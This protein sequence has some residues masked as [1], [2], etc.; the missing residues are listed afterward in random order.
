MG[1]LGPQRQGESDMIDE[2]ELL[3][4][5]AGLEVAGGWVRSYLT[6]IPK[7]YARSMQ[8]QESLGSND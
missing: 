8:T 5:G 1:L 3:V 2:G 4:Q 6:L 7:Q